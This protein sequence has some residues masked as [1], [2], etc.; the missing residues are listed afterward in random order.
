MRNKVLETVP[1]DPSS[2]D[3]AALARLGR[4]PVLKRTFR[5][6]TIVGFS[7]IV[8]ITW[9]GS[10][11]VFSSGLQK[12]IIVSRIIKSSDWPVESGRPSGIIYGF[13]LVWGG[14]LF[15]FL[16]LSEL[17]W[18]GTL[19]FWAVI[20]L[21][22]NINPSIRSVLAQFG[23]IVL[24]IHISGFF[25][26]ILPLIIS[27]WLNLGDWP[28]QDLS[29]SIEILRNAF[30]FAGAD[31]AIHVSLGFGMMVVT[32]YYMGDISA[33][34]AENPIFP[35]MAI[36][37]NALYSTTAA[38]VLS[39]IPVVLEFS[40]TTGEYLKRVNP[41]TSIPSYA[42]ATTA[43]VAILLCPVNTGRSIAFYGAI[44]ISIVGLFGSY[45]IAACLLLYRRISGRIVPPESHFW[46][47]LIEI[48]P[49]NTNWSILVTGVV[50][51]FSSYTRPVIEI[52]PVL[53]DGGR[54]SIYLEHRL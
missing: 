18:H 21:S 54:E 26:V 30:A 12:Y 8:L 5:C 47:A 49:Q 4:K 35:F 39:S 31:G 23:G 33:A 45:L 51:I 34:L 7:C 48:T 32:L 6:L 43:I 27:T 46:P 17:N 13:I 9:E 19:L 1:S 20:L 42:V 16:T 28:T 52:T 37:C 22:Y 40:A 10:F 50:V 2:S 38:A 44:S 15:L 41:R 24:F 3:D 14:T 53:A 11:S 29:L 36:F 25:A